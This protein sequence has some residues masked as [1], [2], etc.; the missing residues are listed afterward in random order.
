MIES[1]GNEDYCSGAVLRREASGTGKKL[2]TIDCVGYSVASGLHV[3]FLTG[4][5]EFTDM[6]NVNF[7]R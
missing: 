5:R 4:D 3:P 7:I 6:E 2:S 1:T